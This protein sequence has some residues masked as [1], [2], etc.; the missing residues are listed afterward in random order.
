MN[1]T[2]REYQDRDF[3]GCKMLWRQLTQH[4]RD[5]YS[6]QSI[7]GDD[8]GIYFERYLQKT[9]LAGLWVAEESLVVGM[10][11]LLIYEEEAEIEPIVIHSDFRSRGVGTQLIEKIKTEAKERGVEFLSIRPVA[12]NV[13][14]IQCF[15][16]AGFSLLGH[17]DMFLD[18]TEKSDQEW[19]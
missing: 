11:G 16:R 18:L 10:A 2:I 15:H 19:K 3:E 7:G 14:A 12:R 4:H 1:I 6:D 8:P 17:I 13:E 5:I 9:N